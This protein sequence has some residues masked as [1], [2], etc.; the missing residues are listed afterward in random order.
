MKKILKVTVIKTRKEAGKSSEPS[1]VLID[2]QSVKTVYSSDKWGYDGEKN[3]GTKTT[4][5]N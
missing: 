3:K 5:S 4:Y 2:S 1:Y